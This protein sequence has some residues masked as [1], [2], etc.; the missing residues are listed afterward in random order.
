MGDITKNYSY[1]EF[2][3]SDIATSE[4]LDN[5]IPEEYKANIKTLC[6]VI[7]QPINDATGWTNVISSGYRSKE[8]NEKA[9][10]VK[11]SNHLRGQAADCNFYKVTNGK[12]ERVSPVDVE[13][14]VKELGLPFTELIPYSKRGFIHI[15]YT[16]KPL[17]KITPSDPTDGADRQMVY[18]LNEVVGQYSF[19]TTQQ[20]DGADEDGNITIE[21]FN[22][23]LK[24]LG[25]TFDDDG[26]PNEK[27]L[28]F[29][30]GNQTNLE[31]ITERY[32][33]TERVQ[34]KDTIDDGQVPYIKIGTRLLI[35][36]S[37]LEAQRIRFEN[38]D[39]FE[40]PGKTAV[41]Y[42]TDNIKKITSD[43]L[44]Q[45]VWKNSNENVVLQQK[46][47]NAK[48]WVLSRAYDSFVVDISPYIVSLTTNK[49]NSNG[50][51]TIQV[52]PV[53]IAKAT[54]SFSY[55]EVNQFN[56]DAELQ[57]TYDKDVKSDYARGYS[58]TLDWFGTFVQQNDM[59][60]IRF[61]E[62]QM[63][64]QYK[65]GDLASSSLVKQ[66]GGVDDDPVLTDSLVW[67]MIGFVDSV[68]TSVNYD[69]NAYSVTIEG[70]DYTKLFE[71]DGMSF[72]PFNAIFGSAHNMTLM[73]D[74]Q[75]PWLRRNCDGMIAFGM[76]FQ[77]IKSSLGFI[78][79]KCS[80]LEIFG[81]DH[82]Q[83]CDRYTD[84]NT[85]DFRPK[86]VW[87]LFKIWCDDQLNDR[88]FYNNALVNP[89]ASVA[90]FIRSTCKEPFVEV[91]G[92][93]WGAGYDLIIRKPPFDKS[94]IQ[95][96]Y[97]AKNA[98]GVS[99]DSYID[100]ADEDLL[101]FSL[102]FDNRVYSWY[103]IVPADGLIPGM[104][105]NTVALII[106][107]FYLDRYVEVFGN[108]R[109]IVQDPYVLS[110]YLG[111]DKSEE[112]ANALFT[113]LVADYIYAIESTAY[114]PFTRKGAITI[115]GDRR[116]KVGT[117]VRLAAT[118][119]IF[120][121]TGVQQS[122]SFAESSLDRQTV[123]TVERGMVADYIT[124]E[125]YNYFNIVNIDG[126]KDALQK[127]LSDGIANTQFNTTLTGGGEVFSFFLKRT[128]FAIRKRVAAI[129]TGG[130]RIVEEDEHAPKFESDQIIAFQF[131]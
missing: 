23:T 21:K 9:G 33:P 79:E 130:L 19:Y 38:S 67:D 10:G 29:T 2:S 74:E 120:Y 8:V 102:S 69:G 78:F 116:I 57:S 129:A 109:C 14:K 62:L 118:N 113:T 117:F 59:V 13:A 28:E 95:S 63:E 51:F 84:N 1:L 50:S 100:I 103:K 99:A 73:T 112:K 3:R 126:L 82:F 58:K 52:N 101:G 107:V 7:L 61:E 24:R 106:P 31:R 6:E 54:D 42:W 91:L 125:K 11:T 27:W 127:A 110:A 124:N 49:S 4:G 68:T 22:E 72:I 65:A 44:Y 96:M 87:R 86:G 48:V 93:T 128:Q 46:N 40:V 20:G 37:S 12:S 104:D 115:N 55:S 81:E 114:L 16:G 5:S 25:F 60:W 26:N 35:K 131:K 43:P 85:S 94:S 123:L 97:N 83:G 108:K 77:S 70:R 30:D 66:M 47:L 39:V 17:K 34:H 32:T 64:T 15:A 36:S 90:D 122:V 111:G 98:K 56:T 80:Q 89:N 53:K 92:D 75:S 88:I 121:V 71:D 41:M 76:Y 105:A 18:P 119:E 45:S